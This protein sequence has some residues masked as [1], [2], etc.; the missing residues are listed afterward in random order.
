MLADVLL[1]RPTGLIDFFGFP[2]QSFLH[3]LDDPWR[4]GADRLDKFRVGLAT[5]AQ[6]L[7][8]CPE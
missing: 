7:D 8:V 4:T 5:L 1:E 6:G 3:R 2:P